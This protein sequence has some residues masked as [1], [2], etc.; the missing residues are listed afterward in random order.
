MK[1]CLKGLNRFSEGHNR[2]VV[3]DKMAGKDIVAD[4]KYIGFSD[5]TIKRIVA[6]IRRKRSNKTGQ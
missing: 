6:I 2:A 5:E 3:S 1:R 4:L